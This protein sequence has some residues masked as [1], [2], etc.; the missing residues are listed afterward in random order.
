MKFDVIDFKFKI[1]KHLILDLIRI[2]LSF[3]NK[4]YLHISSF[5]IHISHKPV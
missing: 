3:K 2:N 4:F 5:E 1:Q